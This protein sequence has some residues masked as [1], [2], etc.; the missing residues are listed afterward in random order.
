MTLR[1]ER[2]NRRKPMRQLIKIPTP[3]TVDYYRLFET[4]DAVLKERAVTAYA[5]LDWH[6]RRARLKLAREQWQRLR[7]FREGLQDRRRRDSALA[8]KAVRVGNFREMLSAKIQEKKESLKEVRVARKRSQ[9]P[10]VTANISSPLIS[11]VLDNK[12]YPGTWER[13]T[14]MDAV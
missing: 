2:T 9:D 8:A 10:G 3:A 4:I 5:Y 11:T 1:L 12:I 7:V 6:R 14:M 13:K